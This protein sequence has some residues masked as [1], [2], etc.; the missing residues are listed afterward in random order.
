MRR[1][2]IN[3][4]TVGL[5][6][7]AMGVAFL[8]LL[9]AI[10]GRSGPSD[11]YHAYYRNVT[12]VKYGTVVYYDGYQVGQVEEV[13]PERGEQG[14]RYRVTF[15]VIEGWQ[16]PQDSVAKIASGLLSGV[17]ID[18]AGGESG[19]LVAV[20]GEVKGQDYANMFAAVNDIAATFNGLSEDGLRPLLRNL[21]RRIDELSAEYRGLSAQSLRPFVDS[22]RAKIDD[23]QLFADLK[24]L[25]AKLNDSAG[26]LQQLLRDENQ[27][28][29]SA[30]LGN[31]SQAS[32]DLKDLMQRLEDTRTQLHT[33]LADVDGVVTENRAPVAESVRSLR[34]S[35]TVISDRIDSLMYHLDGSSRNMHEFTR[36][37]RENPGVLLKSSPQPA[38]GETP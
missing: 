15:S 8:A 20:D 36:Q 29:V 31:V 28:H 2:T 5:L 23:P 21:N 19:T 9:Y 25:A 17:W 18:I 10:T 13:E 33:L 12:G 32:A 3:Y 34:D 27:A 4:F 24:G 11:E 30:I 37:I 7:I 14:L 16:I 6:V 35:L 1:D 38:Q 26:R 22:L